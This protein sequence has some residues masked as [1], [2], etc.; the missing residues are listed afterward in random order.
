MI[1][2]TISGQKGTR[3]AKQLIKEYKRKGTGSK[4]RWN[5]ELGV[6]DAWQRTIRSNSNAN[7][8][9]SSTTHNTATQK[10]SVKL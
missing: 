6:F 10:A 9:G 2:S 1:K 7:S 8:K 4:V 5:G 3:K